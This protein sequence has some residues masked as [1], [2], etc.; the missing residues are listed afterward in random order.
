M[1]D[2]LENVVNFGSALTLTV[3][4]QTTWDRAVGGKAFACRGMNF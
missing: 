3:S 1:R 4:A 2:N